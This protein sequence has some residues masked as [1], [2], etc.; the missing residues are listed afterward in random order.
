MSYIVRYK[1]NKEQATR[2]ENWYLIQQSS[3]LIYKKTYDSYCASQNKNNPITDGEENQRA[4]YKKAIDDY[5]IWMFITIMIS[6]LMLT[7]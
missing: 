5:N 3:Y 4:V 6:T 1:K 2:Y 7:K